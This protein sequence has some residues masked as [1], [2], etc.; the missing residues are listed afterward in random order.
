LSPRQFWVCH[1]P[2]RRFR[3]T[4]G[5]LAPCYNSKTKRR[6][7]ARDASQRAGRVLTCSVKKARSRVTNCDTLTTESFGKREARA[8]R[9]RLP[10]AF[11]SCRLLV[12][13]AMITVRML[14]RL[15]VSACIT[16]TGR[17]KAGSEPRGSDKSAH[18]ISP[19]RISSPVLT[20]RR[21]STSEVER[22]S[23]EG[24]P[25]LESASTLRSAAP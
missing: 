5:R 21:S 13:T 12:I 3:G 17:L 6:P 20:T 23:A 11:A 24:Q 7:V 15:N 4:P 8:G 1:T 14:L 19:R 16:S 10:G 2:T 22:A 9:S 25:G 18:Q